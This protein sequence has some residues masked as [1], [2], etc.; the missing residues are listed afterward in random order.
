[1][2]S[3]NKI[4]KK[5]APKSFRLF[6]FDVLN[7]TR[8]ELD[9][10]APQPNKIGWDFLIEYIREETSDIRQ[11][12]RDQI[13]NTSRIDFVEFIKHMANLE[14]PSIPLELFSLVKSSFH[15]SHVKDRQHLARELSRW[16]PRPFCFVCYYARRLPAMLSNSFCHTLSCNSHS[17]HSLNLTSNARFSLVRS[18]SFCFSCWASTCTRIWAS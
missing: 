15:I 13:L 18:S 7:I 11:L 1:M 5:I 12:W 14:D 9:G 16:P 17:S 3:E 8:A 4:I 10:S 6:S 2:S